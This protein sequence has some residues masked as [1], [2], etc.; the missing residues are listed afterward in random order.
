MNTLFNI[1]TIIALAGVVIEML[2]F[3]VRKKRALKKLGKKHDSLFAK[4]SLSFL[5]LFILSPMLIFLVHK[6][7]LD[8]FPGIIL[9]ACAILALEIAVRDFTTRVLQGIYE[10]GFVVNNKIILYDDIVDFDPFAPKSPDASTFTEDAQYIGTPRLDIVT[11]S[12]GLIFVN[13][14]TSGEKER[15][16]EFYNNRIASAK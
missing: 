3:F 7:Q 6:R 15:F 8:L 16:L 1:I 10:N 11:E 12:K 5:A 9:Y 4:K 2:S 14:S 13:F